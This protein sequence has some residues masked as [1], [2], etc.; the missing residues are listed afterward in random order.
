MRFLKIALVLLLALG[1]NLPSANAAPL[2]YKNCSALNAAY[3][4]GVAKSATA[5]NRGTGPILRPKV[6][7]TI[8]K[9]NLRLDSDK[10]GIACEVLLDRTN[11]SGN[12]DSRNEY[13]GALSSTD[14]CKLKE[15]K[16]I[17]GAGA[18]GFPIRAALPEIGDLNI[19]IAPI[20]FINA[21]GVGVPSKMF[22]DDLVKIAEWSSFYSRGKST[23]KASLASK[24]WIRAPKGAD[25][26]T[27]AE[28]GKGT[29][30][31]KQS[32]TEAFTE[33]VATLDPLV[34]FRKV[35]FI[36]F[37]FPYQAERQFGTAIQSWPVMIDTSEGPKKL[38]AY[39]EM[40]GF[41]M[42]AS[43]DRSKIW[44]HLIHELLHYQGFIG[45]GPLNGSD[46]G[47]LA[48]Q[49]GA[50]KSVTGWEAFLA[51]WF[52]D[53]EVLCLDASKFTGKATLRLSS[54]DVFGSNPEVV[55]VKLSDE[56]LVAIELRT[57]GLFTR[58]KDARDINASSAL[59]AYK[60]N[61][62]A[63]NYRNDSDPESESKNF[64]SYIRDAGSVSINKAQ[65]KNLSIYKLGDNQVGLEILK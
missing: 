45:H 3:P 55:F 27:C 33:L 44:D 50:S 13:A 20:D 24:D 46:L 49:W 63:E 52:G 35:D 56:E 37:V 59:T 7:A 51:G 60:V 10:D 64:W 40:A 8:F 54:I 15:S 28:C 38:S 39:G 16:N 34:D 1:S 25:W 6:S 36:Y 19:L 12:S 23:Y 4:A 9:A 62:N 5:S 53:A 41:A 31:Q 43:M 21:K 58:L 17:T 65:Y 22:A 2:I 48:N 30:L 47:I 11:E 42:P 18:K 26:Y 57:D 32:R 14:S 29:A 61:V